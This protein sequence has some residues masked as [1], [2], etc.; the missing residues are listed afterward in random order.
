MLLLQGHFDLESADFLAPD[1]LLFHRPETAKIF[2]H[3]I[4]EKQV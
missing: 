4:F 3:D 2:Q 1:I